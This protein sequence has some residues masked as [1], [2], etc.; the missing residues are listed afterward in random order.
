MEVNEIEADKMLPSMEWWMY[1]IDAHARAYRGGKDCDMSLTEI[2]RLRKIIKD[3]WVLPI[4]KLEHELYDED[5]DSKVTSGYRRCR[6]ALRAM[7]E[8]AGG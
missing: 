1:F 7:K 2:A 4:V 8:E 6:D 5:D 3:V